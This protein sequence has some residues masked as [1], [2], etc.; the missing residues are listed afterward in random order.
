MSAHVDHE[1]FSQATIGGGRSEP[2][3]ARRSLRDLARCIPT[4]CYDRPTAKGLLYLGRDVGLYAVAIVL[5]LSS[6]SALALGAGWLLASFTIAGL[7]VIGHDA[8]HGSLFESA[9][10]NGVAGRVAML[11]SLHGLSVWAYGHNRVHHAFPGCESLDF[12]WHPVTLAEYRGM[13]WWGRLRHRIEWSWLGAGFYY[14]RAVWWGRLVRLEAPPG[15]QDSFRRDRVV[16]LAYLV[17]ISAAVGGIGWWMQAGTLAGAAWTWVK[18]LLVPWLV[19]NCLI[20]WAVYVQHIAPDMPWHSRRRW[21]KFTGQVE[22][23]TNLRLPSWLNFFW[24]N[25]F[26]HVP[27]HV[28]PRIPFYNL[29]AAAAALAHGHPAVDGS[30]EYRFG[31]YL[32]TTRRCKL[33]DFESEAWTDYRGVSSAPR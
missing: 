26:L 6:D 32:E 9:R 13:P 30:E 3:E 31:D 8:A 15:M 21:R 28:D 19:W 16:V 4:E 12:V 2:I 27:H 25:I 33:Y 17:T 18:V 5:L 29:P 7:F 22:T 11:P 1:A 20:G 24:H 23:T 10:L 14:V